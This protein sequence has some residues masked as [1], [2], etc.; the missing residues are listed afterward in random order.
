MSNLFSKF[1]KK[2][3]WEAIK[4]PLRLLVFAAIGFIVD[5]LIVYFSGLNTEV[6]IIVSA[7]LVALDKYIHEVRSKETAKPLE[8]FK[9]GLLPF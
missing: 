4:L 3:F 1:D 8:G 6:G 2:A 7:L 5:F 9:R